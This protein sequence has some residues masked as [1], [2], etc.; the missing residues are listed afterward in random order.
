MFTAIRI[1]LEFTFYFADITLFGL[2]ERIVMN[3]TSAFW[4]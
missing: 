1:G 2:D 4:I 3:H